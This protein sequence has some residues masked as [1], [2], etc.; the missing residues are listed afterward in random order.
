[1]FVSASEK[2]M[3]EQIDGR[4]TLG[5]ISGASLEFGRRLWW[6]DLAVVGAA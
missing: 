5:A 2:R 4:S 3:F 1:M 6:P